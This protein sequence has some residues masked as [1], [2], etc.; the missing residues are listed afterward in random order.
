VSFL[1]LPRGHAAQCRVP[2][3]DGDPLQWT[4]DGDRLFVNNNAT[5]AKLWN[6]SRS[7]NIGLGVANW[8]L[9]PKQSVT[10][11]S[12]AEGNTAQSPK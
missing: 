4:V 3:T 2:P 11:N 10:A 12:T 9:I 1:R 6:Q 5:A 7:R 8:P